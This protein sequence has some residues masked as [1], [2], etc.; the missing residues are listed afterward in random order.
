MKKY[1]K[2]PKKQLK[3]KV[4][5][6]KE[7]SYVPNELRE[8]I[9][10]DVKKYMYILGMNNYESKIFYLKKEFASGNYEMTPEGAVKTASTQVDMRYLTVNFQIYP[11]LIDQWRGKNMTNEDVHD[12]IAHEVAHV[13]TNHL[14]RMAT[15]TYKD[16]GE[17]LDS[18]EALTTIVG[19]L[20]SAVENLQRKK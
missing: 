3:K 2:P 19:R 14:Y 18:W 6:Q 17:M 7:I 10:D 9:A 4:K 12:V 11:F 20:L 13:A 16:S 15:S 1:I 8:M 5:V